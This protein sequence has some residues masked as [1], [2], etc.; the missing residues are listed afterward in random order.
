[1]QT[2]PTEGGKR[3]LA[4]QELLRRM[5]LAMSA[6]AQVVLVRLASRLQSLR[7][8]AQTKTKPSLEQARFTL[9]VL[10]PLANRL[11]L[12]QL[13]WE[14]EDL[15]FRFSDEASYH[16]IAKALDE[17]RSPARA[18]HRRFDKRDSSW[19]SLGRSQG[20]GF[21]APQTYL[22]HLQQ[23]AHQELAY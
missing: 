22:Q 20:Q 21:W 17:K 1:M 6:D 13:K 5:F 14:M 11:G 7:F 15:A 4:E 8:H 2:V 10:S 19:F 12:G 9:R 16:Q 3:D 18:I 23:N